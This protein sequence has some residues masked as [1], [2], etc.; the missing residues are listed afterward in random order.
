MREDFCRSVIGGVSVSS[1]VEYRFGCLY[2]NVICIDCLIWFSLIRPLLVVLVGV[3]GIYGLG[4]LQTLIRLHLLMLWY[5]NVE[6]RSM[7]LRR[8]ELEQKQEQKHKQG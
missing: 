7:S 8:G 3:G 2:T 1:S 5:G 4:R 6:E